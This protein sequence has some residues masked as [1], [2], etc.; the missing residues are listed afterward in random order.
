MST[1]VYACLLFL[2]S[3]SQNHFWCA[4][5]RIL[6]CVFAVYTFMCVCVCIYTYNS[7]VS[8]QRMLWYIYHSHFVW[9]FCI[10]PYVSFSRLQ[11]FGRG[12]HL[13][14][15]WIASRISFAFSRHTTNSP[16]QYH[17]WDFVA[18]T[19]WSMYAP[20]K[21]KANPHPRFEIFV[22]FTESSFYPETPFI[23]IPSI[24]QLYS[25]FDLVVTVL[26]H[27]CQNWMY[28]I[29]CESHY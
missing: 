26:V 12:S 8:G 2:Y 21:Q 14:I 1:R 16:W 6:V 5:L 22:M 25:N 9:A 29:R 28:T 24:L 18:H 13:Q 17:T 15:S 10:H 7:V 27:L 23:H 3:C 20:W 19:R 11:H 4:H